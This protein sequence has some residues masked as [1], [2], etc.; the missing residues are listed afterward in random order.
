MPQTHASMSKGCWSFMDPCPGHQGH[1]Q[2]SRK[3]GLL[4]PAGGMQTYS[5]LRPS[6]AWPHLPHPHSSAVFL[7]NSSTKLLHRPM[8]H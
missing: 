5:V 3:C 6:L 2:S 4:S 7:L 8:Q 1:A